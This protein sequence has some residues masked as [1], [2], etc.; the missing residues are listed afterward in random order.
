MNLAVAAALED[1]SMDSFVAE[2]NV[3]SGG[4]TY[5]GLLDAEDAEAAIAEAVAEAEA[6]A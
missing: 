2:A 1:G 5:E 6:A 4:A 3:Q